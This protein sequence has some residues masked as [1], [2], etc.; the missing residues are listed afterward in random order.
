[1]PWWAGGCGVRGTGLLLLSYLAYLV[2]GTGVFWAL[3]GR[4][5]QDR[6]RN[7]QRDKWELLQNYTCLDGPALDLLI[8][9]RGQPGKEGLGLGAQ[10]AP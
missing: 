5:T 8:R 2:L 4:S 7:F 10:G 9:V 6:S 3:E 1:M